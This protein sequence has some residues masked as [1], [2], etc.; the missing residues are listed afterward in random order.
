MWDQKNNLPKLEKK[1]YWILI[2]Q[3]IIFLGEI[4]KLASRNVYCTHF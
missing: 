2:N 1:S 4:G 3:V